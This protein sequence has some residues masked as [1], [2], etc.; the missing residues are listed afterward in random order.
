MGSSFATRPVKIE[1]ALSSFLPPSLPSLLTTTASP[2]LLSTPAEMQY[3]ELPS[4]LEPDAEALARIFG[5]SDKKNPTDFIEFG[6]G[7]SGDEPMGSPRWMQRINAIVSS[8]I[9]LGVPSF[10]AER[11]HRVFVPTGRDDVRCRRESS[12]ELVLP[13]PPLRPPSFP[14]FPVQRQPRQ[15]RTRR[16]MSLSVT[17][18]L[19]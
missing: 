16:I 3:H 1:L 13:F 2:P 15:P 19:V 18:A 17:G 14:Q 8:T 9:S 4:G 5:T 12:S 7:S 6:D 11:R 10:S